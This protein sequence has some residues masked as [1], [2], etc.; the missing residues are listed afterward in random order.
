MWGVLA[1]FKTK[2]KSSTK[3]PVNQGREAE[4]EE[5]QNEQDAGCLVR[6]LAVRKESM[7]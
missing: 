2:A 4:I 5:G 1:L 7:R 6:I 3:I